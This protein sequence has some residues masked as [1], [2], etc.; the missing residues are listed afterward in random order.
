MKRSLRDQDI[1]SDSDITD[2]IAYL[3]FLDSNVLDDHDRDLWADEIEELAA[4]R[5]LLTA[6]GGE[7]HGL[8]SEDYWK[9][10]A[11]ENASDTF[12]LKTSGAGAYFDYDQY[13]DDLQTD[14]TS[15]QF[16]G[17]TYYYLG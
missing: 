11:A 13:A 8:I 14:Y 2:S 7:T 1:I 9:Q 16:L 6:T 12:D 17:M 3:E 5:E 10:Y 15:V 4:L